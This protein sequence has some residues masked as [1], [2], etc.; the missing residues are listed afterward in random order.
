MNCTGTP[1]LLGIALMISFCSLSKF[2][3]SPTALCH[4][5]AWAFYENSATDLMC[6]NAW[7]CH[8]FMTFRI[9]K[10]E[11][12]SNMSY[13]EYDDETKAECIPT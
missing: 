2:N 12:W 9:E 10:Y 11:Y 5:Y 13:I 4:K 1:I 6:V 8:L 3:P 7:E